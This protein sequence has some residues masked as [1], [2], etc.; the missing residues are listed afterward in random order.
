MLTLNVHIYPSA[1]QYETRIMKMTATL[2]AKRVVERVI[3]VGRSA[4]GLEPRERIDE[5]RTVE[6]FPMR[7]ERRFFAA[8]ALGFAG[9]SLRVF[10]R[11]RRERIDMVN[12]HSLSVL[13]LCVAIKLRHR[14]ILI[15]EP[16]ELETETLQMH[17][18]KKRF[19]R[20]LEGL[21][22]KWVDCTILVGDS[23]DAW[24]RRRYKL[25]RTAVVV[26]CPPRTQVAPSRHFHEHFAIPPHIPVFLYQGVFGKGR[27]IELI[28]DAFG[29]MPDEA[30]LVLM[31]YG[32]LWDW[33]EARAGQFKNIH[34]HKAVP[35]RQLLEVTGSA[36]FGLSLFE[37]ISLSNEY[38]MPNKFFEYIMAGIP[39]LAS[40]T[41]EQRAI[42]GRFGIG[43]V[44]AALTAQEI[45]AAAR[46]L[47]AGDKS[48]FKAGLERASREYCW[49]RQE[50]VLER[51][52]ADV[53]KRRGA[54][55]S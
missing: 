16:H 19:C 25:T 12:C 39:V 14:A 21:L 6:R 28:I 32:P 49:E 40:D 31:G 55:P 24:Y 2:V 50:T 47:L 10:N 46:R 37:P 17:G 43:E 15:Y 38:C 23:I 52:Y 30:A 13:P 36:D 42:V 27:G 29:A 5:A 22:V 20:L 33:T 34:I 1:I 54:S 11:F 44:A 7:N 18:L 35:Q 26:N 41:T 9:W 51:I 4:A 8:R 3:V 53:L 48:A 45:R